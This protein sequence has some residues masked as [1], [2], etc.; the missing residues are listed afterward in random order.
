[1]DNCFRYDSQKIIFWGTGNSHLLLF[2]KDA[3]GAPMTT[4]FSREIYLYGVIRLFPFQFHYN[5][6][7]IIFILI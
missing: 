5:L 1:M 2:L 6:I 7:S 4:P 3:H